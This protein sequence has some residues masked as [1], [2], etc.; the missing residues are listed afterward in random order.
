MA[1]PIADCDRLTFIYPGLQELLKDLQQAKA[2][3]FLKSPN[4]PPLTKSLLQRAAEIYR[5]E[6]WDEANQGIKV[7]FDV[8]FMTGW[9]P[10]SKQQKAL[11]RGTDVYQLADL[12]EKE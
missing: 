10:S 9:K 1:L 8:I 4:H 2:T 11:K 3:S 6:F 5:Q 7:S 12:L